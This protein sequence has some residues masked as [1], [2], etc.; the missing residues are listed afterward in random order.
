MNLQSMLKLVQ[1]NKEYLMAAVA[2]AVVAYLFRKELM[3]LLAKGEDVVEDAVEDVGDL[4][5]SAVSG[6]SGVVGDV[7]AAVKSVVP[8]VSLCGG[9]KMPEKKEAPK[10]A[11]KAA[12]VVTG[13]DGSWSAASAL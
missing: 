9:K 13:F 11:P 8:K 7:G 1:K 5:S 10:E 12:K 2:V 4:V 3:Q 6:V